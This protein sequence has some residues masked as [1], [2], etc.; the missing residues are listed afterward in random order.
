MSKKDSL[1]G[2]TLPLRIIRQRESAVPNRR[3]YHLT[4]NE[5][6]DT[7]KNKKDGKNS[8]CGGVIDAICHGDGAGEV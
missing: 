3:Y 5:G 8:H 1:N 7:E 6:Y 2:T 4:K